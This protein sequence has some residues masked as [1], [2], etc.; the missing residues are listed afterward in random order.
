MSVGA[1]RRDLFPAS[2]GRQNALF[3]ARDSTR[4]LLALQHAQCALQGVDLR[5][6]SVRQRACS[7]FWALSLRKNPANAMFVGSATT[8]PRLAPPA[9]FHARQ[10]RS[11][12]LLARF[13]DRN[14][15]A[16]PQA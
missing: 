11:M 13:L 2:E 4:A 6:I 12:A 10:T 7:V 16:V 8:A 9:A 3:A 14:V 15:K 5:S 1:V